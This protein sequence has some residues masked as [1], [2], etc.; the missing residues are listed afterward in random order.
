MP[1]SVSLYRKCRT[2]V[3]MSAT[4]RNESAHS[5]LP[6]P[7]STRPKQHSPPEREKNVLILSILESISS[8]IDCELDIIH[9]EWEHPERFVSSPTAP[10]SPTSPAV[11]SAPIDPA[12]TPAIAVPTAPAPRV[13]P[14]VR[15]NG[16]TAE[17][18]EYTIPPFLAGK[19]QTRSGEPLTWAGIVKLIETIFGISVPDLYDRKTKLL[20]RYKN[21]AF[22]D[23]MKRVLIEES[24]K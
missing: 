13:I 21:T 8:M 19:F 5:G 10:A 17:L 15:W 18:L 7:K 12:V 16:K 24:Q 1:S 2:I 3:A 4:F 22:I 9:M 23:K 11:P 6:A 20:N 14:L